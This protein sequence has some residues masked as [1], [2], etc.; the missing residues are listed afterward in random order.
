M[1]SKE[2]EKRR[3]MLILGI[4]SKYLI[5]V[6]CSQWLFEKTKTSGTFNLTV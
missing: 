4:R 5:P 1:V 3:D 2:R 6:L